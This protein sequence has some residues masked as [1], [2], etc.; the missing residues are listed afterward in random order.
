ML[1]RASRSAPLVKQA[2]SDFTIQ[3]SAL[4]AAA[5]ESGF[6]VADYSASMQWAREFIPVEAVRAG[7]RSRVSIGS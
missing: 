1:E 7:G 3:A 4:V 5:E 2:G 6:R